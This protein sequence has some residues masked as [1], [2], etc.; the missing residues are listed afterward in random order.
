MMTAPDSRTTTGHQEEHP[1]APN[2]SGVTRQA[3]LVIAGRAVTV[4]QSR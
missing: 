3:T 2:M 4:K 1:V